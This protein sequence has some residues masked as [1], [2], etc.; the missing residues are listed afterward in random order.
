MMAPPAVKDNLSPLE[1]NLRQAEN[2]DFPECSRAGECDCVHCRKSAKSISSR[3][4][5][6]INISDIDM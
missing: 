6:K 4:R 5:L 1:I 3:A 2:T